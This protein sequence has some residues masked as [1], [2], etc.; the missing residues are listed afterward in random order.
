MFGAAGSR[1]NLS[2]NNWQGVTI[3]L[4]LLFR[5]KVDMTMVYL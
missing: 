1:L 5:E 4:F 2:I 3:L